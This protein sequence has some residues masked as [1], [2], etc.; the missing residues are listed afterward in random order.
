MTTITIVNFRVMVV[1]SITLLRMPT[2]ITTL[3][4]MK[5]TMITLLRIRHLA[6]LHSA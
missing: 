5:L 1:L 2:S 4:S 6:Q 3:S